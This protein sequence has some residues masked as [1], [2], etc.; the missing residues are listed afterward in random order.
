MLYLIFKTFSKRQS[1]R[2]YAEMLIKNH[3]VKFQVDCGATVNVIPKKY[4]QNEVL[5]PTPRVLQMWNKSEVKPEGAC[6][7]RVR[8]PQNSKKYSVGFI[9]VKE[10]LTPLLGAKVCEHMGLIKILRD[11]FN[12]QHFNFFLS[13][14]LVCRVNFKS[15]A[16]IHTGNPSE[17]ITAETLFAKYNAV[18]DGELGTLPGQQHLEVDPTIPPVISPPRRVPIALKPKLEKELKRLTDS[19]VIRHQSTSLLAG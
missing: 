11:N 2:I 16:H 6:R 3:P 7:V 1:D 18:F 14:S 8:N 17:L 19:G 4:I 12:I 10:N 13:F 5:S 9:V 15:V